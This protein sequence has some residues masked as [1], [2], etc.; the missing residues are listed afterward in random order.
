MSIHLFHGDTHFDFVGKRRLG[1]LVSAILMLLSLVAV[2]LNGG[3]RYGV[4][5]AGALPFNCS[6]PAPWTMR[7]S[8]TPFPA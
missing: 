3:L 8:R 7:R 6:S 2:L 4:D 5:F 1:Y